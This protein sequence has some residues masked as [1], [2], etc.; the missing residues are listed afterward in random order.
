MS[1]EPSSSTIL[2]KKS[3]FL[4]A[5]RSFM[6]GKDILEVITNPIMSHRVP[7]AG[8]DALKIET[9]AQ[10]VSFLHTSPEWEMKRLLCQG[11][12]D[13]YYLGTVFR[14]DLNARWHKPAFTMLEWYRVGFDD[15]A[16]IEECVSFLGTLGFKQPVF[17]HD[18]PDL[19]QD[20]CGMNI[21]QASISGLEQYCIQ[22]Q[23]VFDGLVN[24]D[25]IN[26]WL[27]L[28]WVNKVEPTFSS[29]I[30]VVSKFPV[31]QAAL[32]KIAESPYPHAQRFEIYIDGCEVANGYHELT[33]EGLE[34]R[35]T[36]LLKT[37]KI[38]KSQVVSFDD[39]KCLP[40]CSGVSFGIDRLFALRH[41]C[42]SLEV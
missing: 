33:E 31:E 18:I 12:G 3:E 28:I 1:P 35:F 9:V 40:D 13:I 34:D 14:D 41:D 4:Q 29:G 24:S 25:Q 6:Q 5:I 17:Y 38:K 26:G 2:R 30:H 23:I 16:L 42:L 39:I 10:G 20:I 22:E 27:D 8:V 19:Y 11:S 36:E 21:H 37:T 15:R 7:D 32:A